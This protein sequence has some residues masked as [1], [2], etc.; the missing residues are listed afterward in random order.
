ML[1][2][3]PCAACGG[4][5]P[6]GVAVCGR[7]T[8]ELSPPPSLSVPLG[9]DACSTLLGYDDVERSLITALKNRQRRDLVGW[10][11]AGLAAEVFEPAV[12]VVVTW[13]PTSPERRR[14]RGFDQAE[15]LAQA[16]ARRWGRPCRPLLR[17]EPGPPQAGRSRIERRAHPG[18]AALRPVPRRVLLVDDVATTGATLTAAARALRRAGAAEVTAVVAAR[19]SGRS[20]H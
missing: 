18:F 2:T 13:A 6:A 9:L 4:L 3:S 8:A 12:G 14:R 16:L 19:A 15:L 1:L 20:G 10:L 11:A 7:C 5:A 17:R